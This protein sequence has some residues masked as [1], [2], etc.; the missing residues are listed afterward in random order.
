MIAGTSAGTAVQTGSPMITEG[1]SYEALVGDPNS[2]V[3]SPPFVR[4]LYYNPVGGFDFF[5]YGLT[6]THFSARGRQGRTIRLAGSLDVPNV[7]GMD[8]N[9][10]LVVTDVGT[11]RV[12]MEV[13]GELGVSIFDL[14]DA[15]VSDSEDDYWSISDVSMT[16]LT[17]GDRYNPLTE[18]ATFSEKS[19][20][21]CNPGE[22]VADS[23]DIF[24]T[25]G[26]NGDRDNP[27]EF[28]ETALD[29][30]ESC[31]TKATGRSASTNPVPF[32]VTMTENNSTQGYLGA[33]SQG[34]EKQSF[35]NLVIDIQ[36][37]KVPE[38]NFIFGLLGLSILGVR[39][40]QKPH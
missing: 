13:L 19:P 36:S 2:L 27:R 25:L 12:S 5:P 35:T 1:E 15:T 10:A 17:E 37:E 38:P 24:S 40:K 20:L 11:D 34:V 29:L 18:T 30:V 8:E 33:D 3:G 26:S 7:Y 9:T 21:V 22:T 31:A 39:K 32:Q 14:S 28:I 23:T 4:D 16:Y 6:D